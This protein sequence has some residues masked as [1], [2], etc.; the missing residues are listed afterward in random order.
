MLNKLL[1]LFLIPVLAQAQPRKNEI[2]RYHEVGITAK[3]KAY[4]LH[5][6]WQAQLSGTLYVGIGA[7]AARA[8]VV[9]KETV[10]KDHLMP[11]TFRLSHM[12]DLQGLRVVPY[13]GAGVELAQNG[14]VLEGGLG[15]AAGK[16][17]LA[18]AYRRFGNGLELPQHNGVFLRLSRL[19]V[20]EATRPYFR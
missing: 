13:L 11:V 6:S 5:Y 4:G 14:T 9:A 10:R 1:F 7:E 12:A 3:N 16:W 18:A 15:V 19:L 17:Q 8:T 20:R 2:N